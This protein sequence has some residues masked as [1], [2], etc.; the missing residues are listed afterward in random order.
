MQ[1]VH[2]FVELFE[3]PRKVQL[4]VMNNS[5]RVIIESM[6]SA[7]AHVSARDKIYC[8]NQFSN[9]DNCDLLASQ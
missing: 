2:S 3:Y 8:K 9:R 1:N 5:V 7:Q 4:V 6:K